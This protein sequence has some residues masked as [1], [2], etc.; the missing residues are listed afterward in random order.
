MSG[1]G[2]KWHVATR[3]PGFCIFVYLNVSMKFSVD[4]NSRGGSETV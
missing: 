2:G 3:I 1:H 4:A